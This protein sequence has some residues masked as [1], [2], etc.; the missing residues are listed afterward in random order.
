MNVDATVLAL[1]KWLDAEHLVVG[2]RCMR[3]G[4][5]AMPIA[6]Q[7]L[8]DGRMGDFQTEYDYPS[9]LQRK[10]GKNQAISLD[11][12]VLRK[13]GSRASWGLETKW[14]TNRRC[15]TPELFADVFRLAALSKTGVS[16]CLLLMAGTASNIKHVFDAQYQNKLFN[17]LMSPFS[18]FPTK[19]KQKT[20]KFTVE[21]IVAFGIC[22]TALERSGLGRYCNDIRLKVLRRDE[23]KTRQRLDLVI[24]VWKVWTPKG[25]V[26]RPCNTK[27]VE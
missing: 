17:C 15:F 4:F 20:S 26:L 2:S 9:E 16:P 18:S 11:F 7:C 22:A 5:L 3:E 23:W 25:S 1:R 24:V 8:H 6:N 14:A 12:A 21:Q 10:G 19:A 27:V 13:D